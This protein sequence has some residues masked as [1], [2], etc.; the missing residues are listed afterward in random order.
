MQAVFSFLY[1]IILT[2]ILS[3]QDN[4]KRNR[5]LLGSNSARNRIAKTK[6]QWEVGNIVLPPFL[7]FNLPYAKKNP[8]MNRLRFSSDIPL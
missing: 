1:L 6:K 2:D 5:A 4:P 3:S 7:L 8:F